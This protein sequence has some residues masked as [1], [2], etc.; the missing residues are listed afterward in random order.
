MTITELPVDQPELESKAPWRRQKIEQIVEVEEKIRRKKSQEKQHKEREIEIEEE[1]EEEVEK[2]LKARKIKAH[3]P[4]VG[5]YDM[6]EEEYDE[7]VPFDATKQKQ[8]PL[9]TP[10]IY[11]ETTPLGLVAQIESGDIAQTKATVDLLTHSA[12]VEQQIQAEEKEIIGEKVTSASYVAKKSI[13]TREAYEVSE[14]DVQSVPGQFEGNFK[15]TLSTAFPKFASREGI[16][17]QEVLLGDT[18]T[19]LIKE[20]TKE[21]KADFSLLP[22]EATKISEVEVSLKEQ[23]LDEFSIPKPSQASGTFTTKES[24]NVEEIFHGVSESS[25]EMMKPSTVTGKVSIDTRE[26]LIVEEVEA[27]TKP[28]KHLPEAFVPTEIATM[29]VIPQ[30]SLTQSQMVAPE[31]EGEYVPGRLPPTQKADFKVTT[32]ESVIVSQ[33]QPQDKENV[34]AKAPSP[35]KASASEDI[36]LSEGVSVSVTD[37]QLPQRDLTDEVFP[38]EVANVEILPK[39]TFSTQTTLAVESEGSYHPGDK[40]NYKTADTTIIC[41]EVNDTSIVTAQESENVL[42]LGEKPVQSLAETS[43]RPV[44][45]LTVS[46]VHTT[47]VPDEFKDYPKFKTDTAVSDIQMLEA[48]H[49]TE[50]NINEKESSYIEDKPEMK[51][52]ESNYTRPQDQI[53]VTEL[54]YMESEKQLQEFELPE[55]HKSKTVTSHTL[56]TGIVEEVNPEYS[57]SNLDETGIKPTQAEFSQT[58]HTETVISEA[59]AGE[60]F[61][62]KDYEKPEGKQAELQVLPRESLNISEVFTD[63]KEKEYVPGESPLIQQ[64]T[65]DIDAQKVASKTEVQADYSTQKLD[66]VQPSTVVAET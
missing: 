17:V 43:V 1:E 57:A 3:R 24:V 23:S 19:A 31:T 41:H 25:L 63:D 11:S 39:E 46:E 9:I 56:P 44:E 18:S 36:I 13:D 4:K 16:T 35:E 38:K 40:P 30:K 49:I 26:S 34:F 50:T 58:T 21:F 47:D 53:E 66:T 60:T 54:N 65:F 62:T 2:E 5:E 7:I 14:Q 27:E 52:A 15:P 22:Q 48:T 33:T 42:D 32:G 64:A 20:D 45:S 10:G 8:I 51:T 61:E 37:S 59:V 12:L 29:G 55:S 6:D 28:G